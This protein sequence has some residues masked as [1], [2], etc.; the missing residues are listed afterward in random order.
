MKKRILEISCMLLLLVLMIAGCSDGKDSGEY[1][2]YY[3]SMDMTK[4]IETEVD[5]EE[6][7]PQ[8]LVEE[9]LTKLQEDPSGADVRR[10]IPEN[11][12]VG[13]PQ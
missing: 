8:L 13:K 9:M 4:T 6:E 1:K 11:I 5:F 3:L 10:A 2:I 12:K 7:Q